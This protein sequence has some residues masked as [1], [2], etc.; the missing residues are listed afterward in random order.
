MNIGFFGRLFLTTL[1]ILAI[2]YVVSGVQVDGPLVAAFAAVLLLFFNF[3]VKPLLILLTLPLTVLTLGLFLFVV[4]AM[5]FSLVAAVIP[6]IHVA[7]FWSA[8]G[9]SL[10]MSAVT[11]LLNLSTET[12]GGRRVIIVN[13]AS[14]REPRMKDVN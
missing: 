1:T 14:G 9:A 3:T 10:L 8:L 7:S 4:N 11:W 12:Q 2:P 13:Q 5:V 6:G